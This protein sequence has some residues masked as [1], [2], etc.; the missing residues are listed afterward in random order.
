MNRVNLEERCFVNVNIAAT[1]NNH[2][3]TESES[4]FILERFYI[5]IIQLCAISYVNRY[6]FCN[7]PSVP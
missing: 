6:C 3:A 7:V 4:L 1:L 5:C 2:E